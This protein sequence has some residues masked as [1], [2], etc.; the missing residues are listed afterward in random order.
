MFHKTTAVQPLRSHLTNHPSKTTKI[1]CA[2]LDELISDVLLWSSIHGH[3]NVGRLARIYI[4]QLSS[5]TGCS[6]EDLSGVMD[7]RERERERRGERERERERGGGEN[8]GISCYQYD[9]MIYIFCVVVCKE[10]YFFPHTI[11]ANM[12]NL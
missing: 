8:Q 12:N 5:D 7:E 11:L 2:L 6:L 9:L 3:P 10:F 4:H 1:C